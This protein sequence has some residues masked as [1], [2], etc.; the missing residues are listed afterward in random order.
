MIF[1][2]I[3]PETV[4]ATQANRPEEDICPICLEAFN[5]QVKAVDTTTCKHTFHVDCLKKALNEQKQLSDR[6][7][8]PV[9]RTDLS[10]LSTAYA[11]SATSGQRKH[12]YHDSMR[13]IK[14]ERERERYRLKHDPAYA[15]RQ[16]QRAQREIHRSNKITNTRTL[17]SNQTNKGTH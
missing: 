4:Q 7:T 17:G 5:R 9:C 2:G 14:A 13:R 1:A 11:R 10:R 12:R 16:R 3:N 6:T 15:E 8:C